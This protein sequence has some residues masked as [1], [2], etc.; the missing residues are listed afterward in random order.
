MRHSLVLLI[1]ALLW[2]TPASAEGLKATSFTLE[3]GL[4][5]RVV[6]YHRAPVVT[7]MIW[8]RAGAAD[9]PAGVSGVAHYLEHMMF[10][11]TRTVPDGEYTKRIE[12]LGG[13]HN[14]FTGADFTA[15]YV[16]IAKEHLPTVMELEADRMQNLAPQGF[17]AERQVI[18]EE[19]RSRID[20]QPQAMLAEKMA[21]R[22]F[23]GHPYS[24]P[25]IG[26]KEEMARL[27]KEHVMQYYHTHYHPS[28]A[29]VVLVGDINPK[30]ARALAEKYYGSWPKGKVPL[31]HWPDF[32]PP[33]QAERVRFSHAEVHQPVWG[34]DYTAPSLVYG[35]TAQAFPLM[36]LADILGDGRS[37]WLYKRLVVDRKLAVDASASYSGFSLGP[38]TLGVTLVPAKGV[39]LEALETA[40]EE[41]RAAFLKTDIMPRDLQRVK[42]KLKAMAVYLRDGLQGQAFTLGHL[43]MLGFDER[44]LT[45]WS[46]SIDAV[47]AAD[48]IVAAQAVLQNEHSV[49]GELMPSSAGD[50]P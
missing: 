33:R 48:V 21:A 32:I 39:T 5:V 36:L 31:R 40:Y 45:R 12:R 41:E 38:T 23:A 7:H 29:V 30:E 6:E 1:L 10:K 20:N 11:G 14:A 34:R 4:E 3:N 47:S 2:T 44:F 26:W 46:Q 35:D 28:A 22:L 13:E 37:S 15:Y 24:I 42:N 49:T 43:L 9:E 18:I 25:I 19:R 17:E 50:A 16:T 8:L 27:T